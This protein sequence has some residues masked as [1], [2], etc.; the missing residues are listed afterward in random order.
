MR[1]HVAV[2]HVLMTELLDL[3]THK[4]TIDVTEMVEEMT[5]VTIAIT[6]AVEDP[7]PIVLGVM[8]NGTH[9]ITIDTMNDV[10]ERRGVNET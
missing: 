6:A 8:I 3:T 1:I 4:I 5:S 9:D 2:N 10:P 7:P